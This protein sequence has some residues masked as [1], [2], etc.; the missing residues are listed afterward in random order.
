MRLLG[1]WQV[2]GVTQFQTGTPGTVATGDDFAGVG[3][4]SGSQ[5]WQLNG[6]V[7]VNGPVHQPGR[8]HFYQLH[9]HPARHA[10]AGRRSTRSPPP[11][12]S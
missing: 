6:T 2:S 8:R 11:A 10:T 3:T 9:H 1:G 12:R 5:F 7:N 4:G